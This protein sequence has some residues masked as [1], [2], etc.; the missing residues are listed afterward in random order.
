[1]LEG[2][3]YIYKKYVP[4]EQNVIITLITQMETGHIIQHVKRY[5]HHRHGR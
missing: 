4:R 1:M 2:F 3:I 5:P